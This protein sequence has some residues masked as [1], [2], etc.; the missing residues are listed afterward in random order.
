MFTH[1]STAS[2]HTACILNEISG[3]VSR[4]P[5]C[6][7]QHNLFQALFDGVSPLSSRCSFPVHVTASALI[8][9]PTHS[10]ILLLRHRRLNLWL[11]PGGHLESGETPLQ[12]AC[13]EINEETG[14]RNDHLTLL[15]AEP[16]D[17]DVHRIGENTARSEPSHWHADL[18]YA[19]STSSWQID[20]NDESHSF[21]WVSV[22]DDIVVNN[23][24]FSRI[25]TSIMS[26]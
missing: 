3:C 5:A 19:M 9:S 18:C 8:L 10:E 15:F 24:R 17:F 20:I 16:V 2:S 12:G 7:D 25:I 11:Q 23:P 26:G 1:L 13:R 4:V 14:L 21:A 6:T 22:H